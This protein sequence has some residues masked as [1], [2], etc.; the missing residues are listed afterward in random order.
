MAPA[1]SPATVDEYLARFSPDIQ[2]IV[3]RLREIIRQAVPDVEEKI[4]YGMPGYFLNDSLLSIGVWK[5]HIGIYPLTAGMQAVPEINALKGAKSS[6]HFPLNKPF[7]YELF[8]KIVEIRL[9]ENKSGRRP[10]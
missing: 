10:N 8:R 9:S 2:T 5:N 4:S 3:N 7:P 1:S 6:I